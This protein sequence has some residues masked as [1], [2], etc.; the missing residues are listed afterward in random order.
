VAECIG[1][2][3]CFVALALICDEYY[4]AS[5]DIICNI[6]NLSPDVAGATFM[7]IGL[8][9]FPL[10]FSLFWVFTASR[11]LAGLPLLSFSPPWLRL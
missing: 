7:A 5:L 8:V 2:L 9:P 6:F 3:Y 10:I 4:V 11:Y 1:I